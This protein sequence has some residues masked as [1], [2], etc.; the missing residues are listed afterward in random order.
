MIA[1]KQLPTSI[2]ILGNKSEIRDNQIE[3]VKKLKNSLLV[4][5]KD[6]DTYDN[7]ERKKLKVSKSLKKDIE[8]AIINYNNRKNDEDNEYSNIKLIE[9]INE[10]SF[11]CEVNSLQGILEWIWKDS[12]FLNW[13]EA[14]DELN[15]IKKILLSSSSLNI[16]YIQKP[17]FYF[18]SDKLLIIILS[19]VGPN[20][21]SIVSRKY[22]QNMIKYD[23]T[24]SNDIWLKF[25]IKVTSL[26]L[27]SIEFLHENNIILKTLS[28]SFFILNL[29]INII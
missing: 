27:L 4:L 28:V 20:L 7:Q 2:D 12:L 26:I 15:I 29:F 9:C 17:I 14:I 19:S 13:E 8:K 23:K 22:R 24:P 6:L 18:E 10:T 16:D 5:L 11:K 1:A 25:L 3:K 21:H